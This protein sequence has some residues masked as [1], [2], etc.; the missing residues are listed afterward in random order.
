M[1]SVAARK[2]AQVITNT[3]NVLA[4]EL[5]CACQA[6]EFQ[7]V[8]DASPAAGAVHTLV[9]E[10]VA[11]VDRDRG[12]HAEVGALGDRILDGDIGAAAQSALAAPLG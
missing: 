5:V 4:L 3:A 7:G 6:L 2:A 1:G 10:Q 12:L 8:A 9:R 11:P